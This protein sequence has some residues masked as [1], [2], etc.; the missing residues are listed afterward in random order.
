MEK[1]AGFARIWVDRYASES[2]KFNVQKEIPKTVN[3]LSDKQKEFLIIISKEI[4]N[5][6]DPENLQKYLYDIGKDLHLSSKDTFAAIYISFIG[7]D[8]GPK[9]G[10]LLLS[11]DKNFVKQRCIEVSR[12]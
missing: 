10:W 8:H 2:E 1:W 6:L 11:L 4:D 12:I 7:K 5:H 9:A 3:T